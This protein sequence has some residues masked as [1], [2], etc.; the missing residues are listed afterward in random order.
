[1]RLLLAGL[2][3][4]AAGALLFTLTTRPQLV[5]AG[6]CIAGI[7]LAP[8]FPVTVSIYSDE[9]SARATRSASLVFTI[10]NV[11]G[12]LFPWLIGRVSTSMSGLR[13]GMLVPLGCI[14]AMLVL[15]SRLS[16][17]LRRG[18]RVL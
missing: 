11:G 5:L 3:L 12:A 8:I 4:G 7:G 13:Y 14:A 9:L 6:I 18:A 1:V 17:T 15:Q 16:A 10:A 2:L